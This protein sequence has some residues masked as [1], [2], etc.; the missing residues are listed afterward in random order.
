MGMKPAFLKIT[1]LPA[2]ILFM[3][4]LFC[5]GENPVKKVEF[6]GYASYLFGQIVEGTNDDPDALTNIRHYWDQQVDA[7][8]GF[9]ATMSER[10]SF[11]ASIE[12]N[13]WNP[14]SGSPP[15]VKE[16]RQYK[17]RNY[18]LW[19]D[20]ACGVYS[21]GSPKK[22]W[23]SLVGGYFKYKYNPE[24]RNL[25][26]YMFRSVAYPGF[27]FNYF[28]FPS[29]RLLGFNA[30]LDL[31]EGKLK[32]DVMLI[33]ESDFYPFGD[34]SPAVIARCKPIPMIDFGCGI[35]ACRLISVDEARTTPNDPI[36]NLVVTDVKKDALG[37]ATVTYDS[38]S[39]Y[40]FRAIK[41]MGRLTLD[42]KTLLNTPFFGPEDGKIYGEIAVLGLQNYGYFY[43][44]LSKRIPWMVGFNLPAFKILDVWSIEFENYKFPFKTSYYENFE[45]NSIP[46]PG[47]SP[48]Q[49]DPSKYTHDD[50][51]WSVYLKKK[52]I[53]GFSITLQFARDHRRTLYSDGL[54]NYYEATARG[55]QW[56]WITKL[57][58]DL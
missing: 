48:K 53:P 44:D 18:S 49:W 39:F 33:S 4:A 27:I 12:G 57:C 51:K 15:A 1:G 25:G 52:V 55:N 2:L 56:W 40:T 54:P 45:F 19:L 43:N 14:F 41:L 38:G 6:T 31:L 22:P 50:W 5:F 36:K 24:V 29:N 10:F 11:M 9:R 42:P 17:L 26:E 46:L 8:V 21:F 7:A 20:E 3:G 35:E 30:H 32:T 28:D 47:D 58:C 34:I 37:D 13:M 23:L 16:Q